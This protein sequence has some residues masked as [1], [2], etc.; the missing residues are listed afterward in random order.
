LLQDALLASEF[1]TKLGNFVQA[2]CI[3]VRWR[4]RTWFS[5]KLVKSSMRGSLSTH[6]RW[7][8]R[9]ATIRLTKQ[10]MLRLIVGVSL[11]ML[12]ACAWY[13]RKRASAIVRSSRSW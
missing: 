7:R 4:M 10:R 5:Q 12:T 1:E 8:F 13:G 3:V 9:S 6:G 2:L 11:R